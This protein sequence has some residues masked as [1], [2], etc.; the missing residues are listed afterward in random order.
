LVNQNATAFEALKEAS[1]QDESFKFYYKSYNLEKEFWMFYVNGEKA[2]VGAG[3]YTVKS[4]DQILFKYE[5]S[6]H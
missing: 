5:K 3:S 6:S 4:D 2:Q 1:R